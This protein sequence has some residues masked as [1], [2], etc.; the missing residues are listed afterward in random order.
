M[1]ALLAAGLAGAC[2]A[3]TWPG[4]GAGL[5]SVAAAA[6][7]GLLLVRFDDLAALFAPVPQPP[8]RAGQA[9]RTGGR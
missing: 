2:S 3:R 6:V 8:P 7:A 9:A 1:L 4:W 5:L